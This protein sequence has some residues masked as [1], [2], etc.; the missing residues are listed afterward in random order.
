M[1]AYTPRSTRSVGLLRSLRGPASVSPDTPCAY[2]PALSPTS[3]S[4]HPEKLQRRFDIACSRFSHCRSHFHFLTPRSPATRA[5]NEPRLSLSV[6]AS[7]G[8]SSC[9]GAVRPPSP[10][11]VPLSRIH[12]LDFRDPLTFFS[13]RFQAPQPHRKPFSSQ[14]FAVLSYPAGTV[15][16]ARSPEANTVSS[17]PA[18]H[19]STSLLRP[20]LQN[21]FQ[22]H[23]PHKLFQS[24][25]AH[26]IADSRHVAYC[27]PKAALL[28]RQS[29]EHCRRAPH[30]SF[31][32]PSTCGAKAF[33]TPVERRRWAFL[34]RDC[35]CSGRFPP[36]L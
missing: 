14:R 13:R 26:F 1:T 5:R 9:I 11:P 36:S 2:L 12:R 8:T 29:R 34:G 20:L 6:G 33:L 17:L 16:I 23:I 3:C 15:G 27:Q 31:S 35:R 19:M 7:T 32:R 21:V 18:Q 24:V 28:S 22:S 25:T 30:S 4:K 10:F